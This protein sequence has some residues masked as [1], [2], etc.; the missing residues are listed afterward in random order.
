MGVGAQDGGGEGHLTDN[1]VITQ[2]EKVRDAL[3][4]P[5]DDLSLSGGQGE[6]GEKLSTYT[7]SCINNFDET[8]LFFKMIPFRALATKCIP[9]HKKDTSR[10]TIGMCTN[11]DATDRLP[12]LII[13]KSKMPRCFKGINLTNLGITYFCCCECFNET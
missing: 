1:L 4:I 3:K 13:G 7:P 9:G 6:A 2:A 12:L 8:G 11:A 5:S 10:L